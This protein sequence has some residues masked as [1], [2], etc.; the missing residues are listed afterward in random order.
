M[1]FF[2]DLGSILEPRGHPEIGDFSLNLCL[3][4]DLEP[5]WRLEGSESDPRELQSSIFK[6]LCPFW[7]GF[8][9]H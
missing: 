4:V 5:S 3:G 8:P 2:T 1:R 7:R 6:D 9:I